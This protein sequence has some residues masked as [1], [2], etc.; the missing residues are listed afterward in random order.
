MR[1][2]AIQFAISDLLAIIILVLITCGSPPGAAVTK[3]PHTF[4]PGA[5]ILFKRDP[6][7]FYSRDQAPKRQSE[8]RPEGSNREK[9]RRIHYE[10]G[11]KGTESDM[12]V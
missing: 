11:E 6:G 2:Q 9:Q 7:F 5:G 1:R 3:T 8:K 12:A 4:G 10:T